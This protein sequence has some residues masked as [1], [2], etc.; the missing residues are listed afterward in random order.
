MTTTTPQLCC[1]TPE[2]F[3]LTP[4]DNSFLY[5][6]EK[7]WGDFVQGAAYRDR[8]EPEQQWAELVYKAKEGDVDAY[9]QALKF[10]TCEAYVTMIQMAETGR[11]ARFHKE[12]TSDFEQV[13]PMVARL[14]AA[15]E[16]ELASYNK[17]VASYRAKLD[18][19]GAQGDEITKR[20]L[21]VLAECDRILAH[22]PTHFERPLSDHLS[23]L[24]EIEA[25]TGDE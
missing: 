23:I 6:Q 17:V 25:E 9:N 3:K 8:Y 19:S 24:S 2:F 16:A 11:H 5:A 4:A 14:K 12:H 1:F 10:G 20:L 22:V 15:C 18:C 7:L 13:K 21:H